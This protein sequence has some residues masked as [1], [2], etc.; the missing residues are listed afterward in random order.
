MSNLFSVM[1]TQQLIEEL[2]SGSDDFMVGDVAGV[3]GEYDLRQE[4][5]LVD[6][7]FVAMQII[8]D[9]CTVRVGV[10][11]GLVESDVWHVS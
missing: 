8:P 7:H 3:I 5:Q 6:K 2:G 9:N 11:E 4:G 1:L 10:V